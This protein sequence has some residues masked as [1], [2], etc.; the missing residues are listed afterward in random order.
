M[1]SFKVKDMFLFPGFFLTNSYADTLAN[2]MFALEC[3]MT[4]VALPG[5]TSLVVFINSH[6]F[7]IF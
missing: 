6:S 7:S 3:V 2:K 4:V 5:A 1:V